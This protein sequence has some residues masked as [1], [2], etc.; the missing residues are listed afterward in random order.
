MIRIQGGQIE[1]KKTTLEG[2]NES[3]TQSMSAL[4]TQ[5][6]RKIKKQFNRKY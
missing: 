5:S 3:L 2:L 6:K 1:R 4:R